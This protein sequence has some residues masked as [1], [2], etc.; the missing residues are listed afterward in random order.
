MNNAG[1]IGFVMKGDYDKAATYDFLDVVYFGNASYVAKKLTI[2]NEPE[3]DSEYWQILATTPDNAVTGIKGAAEAD[4]RTGN[5]IISPKNIGLGN[6]D[7]T[8]DSEKNVLSAEKLHINSTGSNVQPVYFKNG[9]PA[10]CSYKLEK[11]VPSN[12]VF[13]DTVYSLPTTTASTLGGIKTGYTTSGKNYKVQ[14]DSNGNGYVNVPWTDTTYSSLK[15]PHAITFTG[16]STESY[17]GSVSKTISIPKLTID[18]LYSGKLYYKDNDG[19]NT[20]RVTH[21]V[22]HNGKEYF[23]FLI[24]FSDGSCL[25]TKNGGGSALYTDF[26]KV[27]IV[28]R[29]SWASITYDESYIIFDFWRSTQVI[30]HN[31]LLQDD[32]I[33]ECYEPK[34]TISYISS[35]YGY[36]FS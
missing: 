16:N 29:K 11:S 26:S 18:Q 21:K 15:N 28:M 10:K 8:P 12:A 36:T 4:F 24:H 19:N 20:N 22:L 34:D 31:N 17:D 35:I 1:R 33:Y 32:I 14:V 9:V 6:V 2:G 5:V 25:T 30:I 27:W 3:K 23:M 7:N 13:T